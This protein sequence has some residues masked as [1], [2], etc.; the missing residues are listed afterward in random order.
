M[1]FSSKILLFGEY[2][3]VLGRK[4]LAIPLDFYQ[5]EFS[6]VTKS[7][8]QISA[9]LEYLKSSSLLSEVLNLELAEKEVQQGLNFISNI[10]VG[11]GV[12]SSGALCAAFYHRYGNIPYSELPFER[13]LDH[14]SLMESFHHQSS[15]GIDPF[16]S[17]IDA[18]ISIEKRK[19]V[20]KQKLPQDL[21]FK[22]F[23]FNSKVK[24]KTA[25][26]V[27]EFLSTYN[28]NDRELQE[29]FDRSD[30]CIDLVLNGLGSEAWNELVEISTHQYQKWNHL[31]LADVKPLWLKGLQNQDFLLKICGAGGGGHYLMFAKERP[32]YFP[33]PLIEVSLV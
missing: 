12:G 30:R 11:G 32:Q 21:G 3:V 18:P 29:Y 16:V 27:A 15:S 10:P 20:I 2:A 13:L 31:I 9:F 28:E 1:K 25:P 14:L 6:I 22:V 33:Y 4:G 19:N 17:L 23:V 5:G 7:D 26:L 8:P 24:R